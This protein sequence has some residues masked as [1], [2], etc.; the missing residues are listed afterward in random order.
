M[1]YVGF[2]GITTSRIKGIAKGIAAALHTA[3]RG[4]LL[5]LSR[6]P[7][8]LTG[9]RAQ[10]GTIGPRLEPAA[11]CYH[12]LSRVVEGIVVPVCRLSLTV[13]GILCSKLCFEL[14]IAHA[15]NGF[16]VICLF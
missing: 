14:I 2:E 11:Y 1:A 8:G 16:P 6:E 12:R 13:W 4:F 5:C 9:L 3:R 10:P 7:K 15:G